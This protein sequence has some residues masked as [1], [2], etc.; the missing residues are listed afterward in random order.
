MGRLVLRVQ[1]VGLMPAKDEVVDRLAAWLETPLSEAD[2][3]LADKLRRM[4]DIPRGP[5]CPECGAN[6]V[7]LLGDT[8]WGFWCRCGECG[9]EFEV[10]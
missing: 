1:G 9:E 3:A 2:A 10:R 6:R 8:P 5:S 4:R 7:R